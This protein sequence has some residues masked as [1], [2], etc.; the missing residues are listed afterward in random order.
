M[1]TKIALTQFCFMSSKDSYLQISSLSPEVVKLFTQVTAFVAHSRP[2][3]DTPTMC[4]QK[5]EHSTALTLPTNDRVV[6]G[7]SDSV[8][9]DDETAGIF[10]HNIFGFE[11][12]P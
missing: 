2:C 11:F 1:M 12:P 4:K 7:A 5:I 3:P 10:L 6:D 9:Y 8:S